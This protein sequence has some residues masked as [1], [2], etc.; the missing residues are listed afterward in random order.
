MAKIAFIEPRCSFNSYGYFRFPLM[1]SLCLGTIL[2]GAGHDVM[3]F[4]ENVK[5]VYDKG[6]G[7][8]QETL[9]KVDV[10]AMSLMTSTAERGYCPKS[11]DNH[12]RATCHLYV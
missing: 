1:G 3:L 5:S 2:K 10:V 6:R 8:L 7:W 12:G 4:R 11:Q 9:T